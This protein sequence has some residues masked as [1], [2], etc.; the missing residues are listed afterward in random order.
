M[1]N[2]LVFGFERRSEREHVDIK[3][4]KFQKPLDVLK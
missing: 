4:W 3:M 2:V 1:L